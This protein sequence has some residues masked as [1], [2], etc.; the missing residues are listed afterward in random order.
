MVR[1]YNIIGGIEEFENQ[2][3]KELKQRWVN[4]E[5]VVEDERIFETRQFDSKKQ[6]NDQDG[7]QETKRTRSG[8]IGCEDNLFHWKNQTFAP[9]HEDDRKKFMLR[10]FSATA[11]ELDKGLKGVESTDHAELNQKP[12]K[13]KK[14]RL[15][16]K[17]SRQSDNSDYD[18]TPFS[19]FEIHY[20]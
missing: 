4:N 3:Q 19:H 6:Q 14:T 12:K 10:D 5:I 17:A 8:S 2:K 15:R 20:I 11:E 18:G 7:N 16:R 13:E 9:S 1:E